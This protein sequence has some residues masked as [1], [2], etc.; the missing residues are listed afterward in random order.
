MRLQNS[1]DKVIAK[2]VLLFTR[3]CL[4]IESIGGPAS[5]L[6]PAQGRDQRETHLIALSCG[7]SL[8]LF[9]C[10]A[11]FQWTKCSVRGGEFSSRL[12]RAKQE[13]FI[14]G[15]KFDEPE[16]FKFRQ[17]NKKTKLLFRPE[18]ICL[19]VSVGKTNLLL[20]R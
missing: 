10:F 8:W 19:T 14:V 11:A 9:H 7:D 18:N 12:F 3:L 6:P 13:H 2:R 5:V 17:N 20:H 16:T 15:G 1:F 4:W